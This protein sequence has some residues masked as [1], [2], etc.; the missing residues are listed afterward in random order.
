M[1]LYNRVKGKKTE[2]PIEQN[3]ESSNPLAPAVHHTGGVSEAQSIEPETT[4]NLIVNQTCVRTYQV[5]GSLNHDV[6][7]LILDT[8]CP[9]IKMQTRVIY[10]FSC[11]IYRGS[12]ISQY[13]EALSTKG[14]L[15][16]LSQ[17]EEY[18]KQC[19]LQ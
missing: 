12:Q 3:E 15:T 2:E 1:G 4:I 5:T 8:I 14:T 6:S 11:S 10:R 16:S 17:I 19:E 7:N 18:I 13:H 9:V